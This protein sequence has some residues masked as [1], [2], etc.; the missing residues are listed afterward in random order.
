MEKNSERARTVLAVALAAVII[1]A[2]AAAIIAAKPSQSHGPTLEQ[3]AHSQVHSGEPPLLTEFGDFQCPHCANFALTILP[4]LEHD[5]IEPGTIR[6]E[7]RHYP[8]L[9]QESHAAAEASECARDQGM[10]RDYHDLLLQSTARGETFTPE[11]LAETA[12]NLD[13][14]PAKFN[15][16][17]ENGEKRT[18]VLEDLEYGSSLGVQ[19]TPSLFMDGKLVKW[20][21]YRDLRDQLRQKA[22]AQENQPRE[23]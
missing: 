10:F 13:L 6:F 17:L 19:G 12:R 15:Q 14:E 3:Q 1:A 20:R 5:L 9:G 18:R 16:C 11:S 23:P 8:F 22:Q 4:A 21:N 7:Y 2:A